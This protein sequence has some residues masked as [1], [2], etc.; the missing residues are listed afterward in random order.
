MQ[1]V[2]YNPN[3][4][5]FVFFGSDLQS[6]GIKQIVDLDNFKFNI[7]SQDSDQFVPHRNCNF[8]NYIP[9]AQNCIA[10]KS[11]KKEIR[12]VVCVTWPDFSRGKTEG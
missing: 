10:S 5:L 8:P 2:N 6:T 11:P 1:R 7:L 4:L 9:K 12:M 3:I